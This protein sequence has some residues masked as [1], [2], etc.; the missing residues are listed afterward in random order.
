MKKLKYLSLL[1]I[2]AL[3]AGCAAET[4]NNSATATLN[5]TQAVQTGTALASNTSSILTSEAQSPQTQGQ[6]TPAPTA[7][8]TSDATSGATSTSGQ[9]QNDSKNGPGNNALR[10]D[11]YIYLISDEGDPDEGETYRIDINTGKTEQINDVKMY[12]MVYYDGW[13][14][15]TY[16]TKYEGE[17]LHEEWDELCFSRI[18]PDGSE[19]GPV[20]DMPHKIRNA[21]IQDGYLY[22]IADILYNWEYND[23]QKPVK[24]KLNANGTLG[25]REL[26][27]DDESI[28]ADKMVYYDSW[29]YYTRTG[30]NNAENEDFGL[31]RCGLDGT[32]N[33]KIGEILNGRNEYYWFC[34]YDNW[35]Y[36]GIEN[37]DK[38]NSD[39]VYKMRL[40]GSSVTLLC[41]KLSL[42][43]NFNY[44]D[45]WVYFTEEDST[46]ST[47]KLCRV[48]DNGTEKQV[49]FECGTEYSIRD[50]VLTE[51]YIVCSEVQYGIVNKEY[52]IKDINIYRMNLDGSNKV[53]LKP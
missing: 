2:A 1:I 5:G 26:L 35:I 4:A 48:R 28:A 11:D 19:K 44:M 47:S 41:D 22:A 27:F 18:K 20:S 24:F 29:L 40:D 43:G 31:Y 6:A 12:N 7:G 13:I 34:I 30:N 39:A 25:E 36:Y 49:L 23:I 37:L 51:D 38:D 15:Y 17:L 9:T 14:Y 45:G 32:G 53:E 3:L 21:F 33:N 8:N 42:D 10:I 46:K 50:L 52:G 16:Y